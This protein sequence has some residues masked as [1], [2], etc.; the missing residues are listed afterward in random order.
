MATQIAAYYRCSTELQSLDHQRKSV[1]DWLSQQQIDASSLVEFADDAI[2]GISGPEQRPG[3]AALLEL[4]AA[5]KLQRVVMFEQSRAS[6]D[7]ITFM[8]FAELCS[9]SGCQLDIVGQGV[10]RY[11]TSTDKLI[12]AIQG[13]LGE[14]EREKIRE[15]TISALKLARIRLTEEMHQG[16]RDRVLGPPRGN[17]NKLGKVKR[18]PSQL[19]QQI[20]E[21][22]A[23]GMTD[24]KIADVLS[25]VSAGTVRNIRVRNRIS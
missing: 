19:V 12:A 13:F 10:Q 24:A 4:I 3:Y 11:T 17:K 20:K 5:R 7:M 18:Y 14:A 25:S 9:Q 15:R 16:K 1:L 8:K 23:V 6:R 2:S 22:R 21:L